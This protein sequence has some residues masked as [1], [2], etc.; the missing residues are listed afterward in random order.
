MSELQDQN[1]PDAAP[2]GWANFQFKTTPTSADAGSADADTPSSDTPGRSRANSIWIEFVQIV[3]DAATD[4]PGAQ[5]C[6]LRTLYVVRCAA[7]G[8]RE[9]PPPP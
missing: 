9:L 3:T 2:A 6:E 4:P 7:R 8:L 5:F 1:V